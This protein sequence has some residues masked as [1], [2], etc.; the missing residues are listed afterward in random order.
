MPTTFTLANLY[1]VLAAFMA[2]LVPD[3]S[4][5]FCAKPLLARAT[6][7]ATIPTILMKE[8]FMESSPKLKTPAARICGPTASYFSAAHAGA[9][10]APSS[11]RQQSCGSQQ[12]AGRRLGRGV[13][14]FNVV[15]GVVEAGKAAKSAYAVVGSSAAEL[16]LG[17]SAGQD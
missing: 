15:N 3:G 12:S 7:T 6:T 17:N 10:P 1:C 16:D 5:A 11:P 13:I 4:S 9:Q 2:G 14:E 8:G